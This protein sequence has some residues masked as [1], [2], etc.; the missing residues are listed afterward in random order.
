MF[1]VC[2]FTILKEKRLLREI[3]HLKGTRLE[4]RK[5]WPLRIIVVIFMIQMEI[6]II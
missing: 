6:K 5:L 2:V 3:A 1:C 4:I